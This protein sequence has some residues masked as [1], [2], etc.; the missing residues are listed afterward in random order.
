[1]VG[2]EPVGYFTSLADDLN[3]EL[4]L[5]NPAGVLVQDLIRNLQLL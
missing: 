5:T 2:G 1:M 4:P 3:S